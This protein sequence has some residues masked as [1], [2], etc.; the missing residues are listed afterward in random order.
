MQKRNFIEQENYV[1]FPQDLDRLAVLGL[2]LRSD[3]VSE[4]EINSDTIIPLESTKWQ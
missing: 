4:M 2:S 3:P 1:L